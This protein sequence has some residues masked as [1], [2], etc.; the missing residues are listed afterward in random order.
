MVHGLHGLLAREHATEEHENALEPNRVLETWTESLKLV[1]LV[2]VLGA[3]G[4]A[5]R[6]AL[7]HVEEEPAREYVKNC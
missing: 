1:I 4:A 7:L 5:G 2:V 3:S 6:D